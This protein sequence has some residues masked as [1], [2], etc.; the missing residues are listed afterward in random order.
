MGAGAPRGSGGW[1]RRGQESADPFPI[2]VTTPNSMDW[3]LLALRREAAK[4]RGQPTLPPLPP[5][6]ALMRRSGRL[7]L[8]ASLLVGLDRLLQIAVL[9]A[10]Q[11]AQLVERA[12]VILGLRQ[13]VEH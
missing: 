7:G 8:A 11:E 10:R 2:W 13:V 9:R 4:P 5:P 1:G 12:Q 3:E 6:H